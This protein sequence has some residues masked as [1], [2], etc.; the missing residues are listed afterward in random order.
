MKSFVAEMEDETHDAVVWSWRKESGH[1]HNQVGDG[2]VSSSGTG[3]KVSDCHCR[4]KVLV[5]SY[6]RCTPCSVFSQIE[7]HGSNGLPT[8]LIPLAGIMLIVVA[9]IYMFAGGSGVDKPNVDV[10][11]PRVRPRRTAQD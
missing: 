5:S 11:S 1:L 10:E 3:A 2:Q 6:L 7:H 4:T 8:H 9:A